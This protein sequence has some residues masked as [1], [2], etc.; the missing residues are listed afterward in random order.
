MRFIGIDVHRD[1]CEVC[2]L[3]RGSGELQRR[4][5]PTRP[6]ELEAF[7]GELDRED[8]VAL[9]TSSPATAVARVLEPH[10]GPVM[11]IDPR[12]L[13]RA[14]ARAKTDRLDART[15]ARLLAAGVLTE[16]WTPDEATRALRRLVSR[17]A[18][19]V[20]ARTRL[21]NEVHAVL[22]RNLCP[23]PPVSD[24]FGKAGRRWLETLE[25][26]EEERLTVRGCL[27]QID[28]LE[29]DVAE[30]EQALAK[31]L[32][33]SGEARRLLSVPGVNL[34]V[35]AAFLAY[36]GD[37]HRFPTPKH[38]VGYL[39][40]DPRV[41][42]S[43]NDPARGGRISKQGA[44]EV[45]HV[46]SE[47]AWRGAR[48]PGPLRGFYER[49]RVRRGSQIAITA[50]ARKLAVLFW[51]L[52]SREQDYAFAMPSQVQRKRRALELL[53]GAPAH[54]G[55][56][57]PNGPCRPAATLRAREREIAVAAEH[58]YQRMIADWQAK[59]PSRT[60]AGAATGERL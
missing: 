48:V 37:I 47:A 23:R 46:L 11:V 49:I 31:R 16:I 5:V 18:A 2:V 17:R 36:V 8:V 34:V 24:A 14:G 60:G 53:A 32:A 15:L 50:T 44:A 25:L 30:L 12:R 7:A 45:R 57:G 1:F 10:A 33:G 27:R 41:S 56:P 4:R 58:A 6:D 51:H 13:V 54:H 38:L 39:G 26:P 19:V 3:D 52:L 55:R 29:A 20:R 22:A 59:P 21:K 9:E 43:G 42:Q 40:L 35:A 28:A